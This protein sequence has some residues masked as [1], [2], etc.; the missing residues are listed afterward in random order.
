VTVP[1]GVPTFTVLLHGDGGSPS[2]TATGPNGE[3]VKSSVPSAGGYGASVTGY[4]ATYLVLTKPKA[5]NWTIAPD[6]GSPAIASTKVSEGYTPASVKASLGGKGRKRSIRYTISNLGHGQRVVFA[7]RGA[8]GTNV[9]GTA[10]KRSGTIKFSTADAKG[11][12]RRIEAMI[13]KDGLLMDR[14]TI[15]TYKAPGPIKP[16]KVKRLRA[17]RKGRSLIVSWRPAK[18]ANRYSVLVKGREG[19]R[20]GRMLGSKARKVR[21]N[22]VG[23]DRRLTVTVVA[24]A[25]NKQ[26]GG[27]AKKTVR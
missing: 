18:N 1:A 23:S 26:R 6:E 2:V 17:K 20:L 19:T 27:A 21:F 3:I 9:V 15:G 8:F 25:K 13:E 10:A 12:K 24:I 7:E 14:K 11:G 22:H 5:G 16:S 4:N